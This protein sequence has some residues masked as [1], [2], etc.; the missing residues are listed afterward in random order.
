MA[1]KKAK[2]I[3][4]LFDVPYLENIRSYMVGWQS[5]HCDSRDFTIYRGPGPMVI[6]ELTA[7]GRMV[8]RTRG[9]VP[10]RFRRKKPKCDLCGDAWHVLTYGDFYKVPC[11]YCQKKKFLKEVPRGWVQ[12]TASTKVNCW[13]KKT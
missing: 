9:N 8:D 2:K 5:S 3:Y 6:F 1:K 10:K 11:P 4:G 12:L 13:V 7:D